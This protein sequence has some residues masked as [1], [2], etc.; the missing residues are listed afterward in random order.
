MAVNLEIKGLLAKLLSTEDIL[1]EHRKV[2]TASFDTESRTLVLPL[3]E[4]ASNT[5]Y[6]ILLSHECAHAI[7]T[8]NVDWQKDHDIPHEYV[9][10]VEDVRIEKLIKRKYMGLSK[11]FYNGYKELHEK[12]FFQI[13]DQDV[14]KFP[15]AD[16]VNLYF[17]IGN[18]LNLKFTPEEQEL[19]DL[20]Y[21]VETF[22]DVLTV[23]KKLYE[24]TKEEYQKFQSQLPKQVQIVMGEPD[25]DSTSTIQI[26][27]SNLPNSNSGKFEKSDGQQMS[28]SDSSSKETSSNEDSSNGEESESSSSETGGVTGGQ[29]GPQLKTLQNLEDNIRKM[30]SFMGASKEYVEI[31]EL[32]LDTV[33]V[34]TKEIHQY[35]E[36]CMS[37]FK[38]HN[39][40]KYERFENAAL[41]AYNKFKLDSQKEVSYLVKEF[42]CRKS[43]DA[44][45]RSSVSRTGV[46]DTTLLPSYKFSDDIFKRVTVIPDGKNHGLVFILD[47]SGSMSNILTDTCKQLYNL[48]WFC[49]K[50]S[51]PFDV[52]AFTCEWNAPYY[53]YMTGQHKSASFKDH[54]KK[55]EYS[56]HIDSTFSLMNILTSNVSTSKFEEQ[57][58]NIWKVVYAQ[59]TFGEFV[60]NR[61]YLSGTPLNESLICLHQVL[62]KFKSDHRLQ[63]VH[64]IVLTD[65]EG[66][67][68]AYISP[69]KSSYVSKYNY[70]QNNVVLRDRK[71]GTTYNFSDFGHY[72]T[73]V[74]IRNL[75]DNFPDMSFIGIRICSSTSQANNFINI[76]YPNRNKEYK[77]IM[78]EFETTKTCSIKASGY[79]SYFTMIASNLQQN[80]T[81]TV[82]GPTNTTL[83][84]NAFL[85]SFNAK[86]LNK[87]I[88]S[89]FISLIA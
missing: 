69:K 83:L 60:P 9:N 43:A 71:L 25:G 64:C 68:V 17:K 11:T 62:P 44:Y 66:S 72:N 88:L 40:A 30:N 63:K 18:F 42:E 28:Q 45:S 52:Y 46:L 1:V 24:F 75:K 77:S 70:A 7:F 8:P 59:K 58:K 76:Y 81:F 54:Y 84:K 51:I 5:I 61:M 53:D 13:E 56:V 80:S 10:V 23:A 27:I 87:K 12:D 67:G 50:L 86:K 33:I 78:K 35:I 47:W 65:G 36:K 21:K 39:V 32:N 2:D 15:F 20:I 38:A 31:P 26:D 57:M 41:S 29:Q 55:K 74:I 19:I 6:D 73:D 85:K 37:A 34:K 3:W 22:D 48:L 16:R 14:S 49:K 79:D 89:D 4:R 82:S